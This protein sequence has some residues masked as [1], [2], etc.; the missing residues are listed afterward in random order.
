MQIEIETYK[1]TIAK[2]DREIVKIAGEYDPYNKAV[3][4]VVT[5][6][7]RIL[8]RPTSYEYQK[9]WKAEGLKTMEKY[10]KEREGEKS[11]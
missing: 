7:G 6:G 5:A 10:G 8:R 1:I 2:K 9:I 3:Y 4:R 11:V